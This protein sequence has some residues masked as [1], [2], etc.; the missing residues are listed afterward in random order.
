MQRTKVFA[1]SAALVSA[2]V[3]AVLLTGGA[4]AATW[5]TYSGDMFAGHAYALDVPEDAESVEFLFDSAQTGKAEIGVYAPDGKRAG[6]YELAT[7]LTAAS[8][9]NPSEGRYVVYVYD[10]TDGALSVR[11]NAEE[12]PEKLA[13]SE[14][15][16]VRT[17]TKIGTFEQGPVDQVITQDLARETVFVTL[18]YQGSSKDLDATVSSAKGAVVTITDESASAFSPGVWTRMTGT[19]LFDASQLDGTKYTIEAHAAQFEG[20]MVLTTLAVKIDMPT[21]IPLV[22]HA[23]HRHAPH[24]P[25]E[26]AAPAERPSFESATAQFALEE[27]IPVAFYA[28][29]TTLLLADPAALDEDEDGDASYEDDCQPLHGVIAIYT[30]G[31]ELLSIVELSHDEAVATVELPVKGEYVAYA[32]HVEGDVILAKIAGQAKV[33]FRALATAEE[34]ITIEDLSGMRDQTSSPVEFVN[35]P[36]ELSLRFVDGIGTLSSIR[37]DNEKGTVAS[38]TALAVIT[39]VDML[40][41]A[42]VQP[43]NFA[44]GQHTLRMDGLYDG[45]VEITSV[46]YLRD[47]VAEA[48]AEAEAEDAEDSS[49]EEDE[50]EPAG[51]PLP[52]LE[53]ILGYLPW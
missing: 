29:G 18:L 30:P 22:P 4:N 44:K 7:G 5:H 52:P 42:D 24:A 17:E 47:V 48:E 50:K 49:E 33:D 10:V 32:R 34:T 26:P 11:V 8:V 23:P 41:W 40:Q 51:L 37:L 19:R 46:H 43:E 39:G 38:S 3:A 45:T 16:L 6:Y 9:A 36:L 35:V 31:D 15:E 12:A 1:V 53:D 2:V 13:L 20:T 27:G 25:A 21:P 14:V 28:E